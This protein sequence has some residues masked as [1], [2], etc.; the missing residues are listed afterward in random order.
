[1]AAG[2]FEIRI[3]TEEVQALA[4]RLGSID[5]GSLGLAAMAG[6]NAV[7]ERTYRTARQR[8]ISGIGLSESYI[9]DRMQ[10]EPATV[11]INPTAF[12]TARYRHTTLGTYG[13]QQIVQAAKH[14]K[15]SKGDARLGIAPGFKSAGISV[16]VT[17]GS[18]KPISYAF[19]MPMMAGN[20]LGGNG[21]GMFK[22]TGDGPKDYEAM[23][24][25]SVYQLFRTAI[26]GMY[27]DIETDLRTTVEASVVEEIRKAL[28]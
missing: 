13:A 11:P 15:R 23:Y 8:M 9:D 4:D 24:G 14:P 10:L 12:I 3:T 16:E 2:R 5:E 22:R 25:P 6:V 26:T 17:R 20:V 7:A 21:M 1:M 18:R 19:F 27:E 28:I